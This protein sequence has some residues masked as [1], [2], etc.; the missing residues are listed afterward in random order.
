M[1]GIFDLIYDVTYLSRFSA[2]SGEGQL[3]LAKKFFGYL[4]KYP[5]QGYAINTQLLTI[6][7]EYEKV[8]LNVDFVNQ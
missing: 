5:K 1:V 8:E 6:D 3:K 2:D 7:M 4:N